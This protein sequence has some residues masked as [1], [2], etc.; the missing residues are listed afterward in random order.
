M[1]SWNHF[2]TNSNSFRT[3]LTGWYWDESQEIEN[4]RRKA[5]AM[6]TARILHTIYEYVTLVTYP[7][8][9]ACLGKRYGLPKFHPDASH[10]YY[11]RFE[12]ALKEIFASESGAG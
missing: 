5:N 2:D 1:C 12:T 10:G 9:K 4:R 6:V 3:S 8:S 7:R 11:W